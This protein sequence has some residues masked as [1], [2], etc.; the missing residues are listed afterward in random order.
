MCLTMLKLCERRLVSIH[1]HRM[2]VMV[3]TSLKISLNSSSG[4]L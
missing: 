3:V 4:Y 1:V 2:S